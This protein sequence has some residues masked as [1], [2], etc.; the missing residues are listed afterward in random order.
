VECDAVPACFFGVP[1]DGGGG[2]VMVTL[3]VVAEPATFGTLTT[4]AV[5]ATCSAGAVPAPRGDLVLELGGGVVLDAFL[6]GF[7]PSTIKVER[8]V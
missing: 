8:S 5:P 4:G 2:T 6:G 7:C 1:P 3:S